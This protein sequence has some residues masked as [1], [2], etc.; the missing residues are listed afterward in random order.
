MLDALQ[1]SVIEANK[2]LTKEE[3]IKY[4]T[5]FTMFT[6]INMDKETGIK[7]KVEFTMD[8]LNNDLYP[9][10]HNVVQKTYFLGY[11]TNRLLQASFEITKGDDRDSYVNKRVDL[12]GTLLNNLFR[13]YFNKLVKDMEKQVIREINTGSWKS[14][15]DYENIINLTNI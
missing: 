8:I 11:M 1:A 12:T 6:P 15:D 13:N 7:K 5:S 4:I 9:H 14:T 2:H 10:C 3:C